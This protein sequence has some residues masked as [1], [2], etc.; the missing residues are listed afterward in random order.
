MLPLMR[1]LF[2]HQAWADAAMLQAI[3]N[4]SGAATDEILQKTLHHVL[5]TQRAFLSL[6]LQRPFDWEKESQLPASFDAAQTLF[7]ETH[8]EQTAFVKQVEEGALSRILDI[9]GHPELRPTLAEALMQVVMHSQAHRAQCATRLR[10]LGGT[11]P[12][13]DFLLWV[14]DRPAP[15]WA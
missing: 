13:T 9:K 10:A 15:V 14:K 1:D 12:T 6:F 4:Q 5:I 8:G 11:P 2:H 3:R 7:R